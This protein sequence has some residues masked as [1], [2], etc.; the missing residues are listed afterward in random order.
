MRH[1]HP[2]SR[3]IAIDWSA[4]RDIGM[5]SRGSIPKMMEL[6]GIDTIPPEAG[7][8][9]VRRE[10]T[11][12]EFN[13]EVLIAKSLGV[14]LDGGDEESG[15]EHDDTSEHEIQHG[16]MA[17]RLAATPVEGNLTVE[18]ELDPKSQPFLYDHQI[19]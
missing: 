1:S 11:C 19:D 17:G 16:P 8:P 15:A 3:A 12:S 7:I 13:G 10:L 9:I 14:L 6:A 2:Q 4:W 5:A 18:T